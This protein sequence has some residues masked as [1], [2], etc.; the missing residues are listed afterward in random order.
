MPRKKT[1]GPVD[2]VEALASVS[3]TLERDEFGRASKEQLTYGTADG[4]RRASDG[5]G[6]VSD[7]DGRA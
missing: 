2:R 1:E 4:P 7:G 6:R 5:D 3:G